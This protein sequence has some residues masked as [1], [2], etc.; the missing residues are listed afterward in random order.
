MELKINWN[1]KRCKHAIERMWLRGISHLEIK[2]AL[3]K[4]QKIKRGMGL[5]ESIY[6]Y[7]SVIYVERFFM[8]NTIRKVYPITVKIME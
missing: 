1:H 2:Q 8:R 5:M 7:Y 4:G 3:L 6:S